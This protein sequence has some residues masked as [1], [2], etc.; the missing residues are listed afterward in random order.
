[1]LRYF[2]SA[3]LIFCVLA[4][5]A[6]AA[7]DRSLYWDS[8]TVHAV[9]DAEGALHITERHAMV[10]NGAW[11][12]GERTFQIRPWQR[13]ELESL[14]AFDPEAGAA[15]PFVPGDLDNKRLARALVCIAVLLVVLAAA[16]ASGRLALFPLQ[17][18]G[19][20][21]IAL[22]FINSAFNTMRSRDSAQAL[23]IRHT[24]GSARKY[25]EH[26][27]G[28]ES[29]R[30]KDEWFPY[31]LAFGLGPMIDRWFKAFGAEST[32][33]FGARSPGTGAGSGHT[34]SSS[35]S[36]WT[37]GGGT[38]GGAGASGSWASA[39]G[40]VASGVTAASSSSGGSSGGGSSSSGGG[41]GGG[42]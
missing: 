37:G 23:Q 42:W 39:V 8:L 12:G 41:G 7:Q 21:A 26:E 35:T 27:L 1:M 16:L 3:V 13:L 38:F 9:L 15:T 10:F 34:N 40:G 19:L 11:N 14:V 33:R 18:V 2:G 29:P 28:K 4:A 22:G 36:T 25:F 30:L 24:L 6:A 20:A 5:G 17:F 31:L 32:H